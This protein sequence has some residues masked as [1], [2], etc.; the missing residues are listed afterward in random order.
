MIKEVL[1]RLKAEK[2]A[3]APMQVWRAYEQLEKNN[4]LTEE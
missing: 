3:L 1:E 4:R 2:P